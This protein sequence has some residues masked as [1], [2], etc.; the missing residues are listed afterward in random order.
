MGRA[1]SRRPGKQESNAAPTAHGGSVACASSSQPMQFNPLPRSSLTEEALI[2]ASCPSQCQADVAKLCREHK[3]MKAFMPGEGSDGARSIDQWHQQVA[4]AVIGLVEQCD[5]KQARVFCIRDSATS[6]PNTA[7]SVAALCVESSIIKKSLIQA[8]RDGLDN[9]DFPVNIER[10][11]FDD[12]REQLFAIS[13]H[14]PDTACDADA[15]A[16]TATPLTESLDALQS[17]PQPSKTGTQ[18]GVGSS[19]N[20]IQPKAASIQQLNNTNTKTCVGEPDRKS[21]IADKQPRQTG[22]AG[23]ESPSAVKASW[24]WSAPARQCTADRSS[25]WSGVRS[26]SRSGRVRGNRRSGKDSWQV[27]PADAPFR[28]LQSANTTAGSAEGEGQAGLALQTAAAPAADAPAAASKAPLS[29]PPGLAANGVTAPGSHSGTEPH[30]R[31]FKSPPALPKPPSEAAKI[32]VAASKASLMEANGQLP[33][34]GVSAQEWPDLKEASTRQSRGTS[35]LRNQSS[36]RPRA[37]SQAGASTR[38]SSQAKQNKNRFMQPR[39][40]PLAILWVCADC[41]ATF[42]RQDDL[43]EHQEAEGHWSP[44]LESGKTFVRKCELSQIERAASG[45]TENEALQQE[46]KVEAQCQV[47]SLSSP[48]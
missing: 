7:V 38:A 36:S 44:T 26:S 40:D 20:D 4:M 11:S 32:A 22:N 12:F 14:S 10:L 41:K 31:A 5:A 30:T 39:R 6:Q 3:V 33:N 1:R 15:T 35:R 13:R 43:M 37:A 23:I 18:H 24:E 48:R 28:S 45:Q 16:A 27:K 46:D 17:T 21:P 25:S 19:H 8:I 42:D 9:A 29:A 34:A 2:C 47:F